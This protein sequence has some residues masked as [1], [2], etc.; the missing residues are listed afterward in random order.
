MFKLAVN[1]LFECQGGDCFEFWIA[2]MFTYIHLIVV[3]AIVYHAL[4]DGSWS[5]LLICQ[6]TNLANSLYQ[7][8]IELRPW[9]ACKRH[10]AHIV[11]R[12]HQTMCQHLQGVESRIDR[13]LCLRKPAL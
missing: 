13:D 10:D 12:H 1:S 2:Q 11:V 3:I 5:M 4:G 8:F 6:H 7:C 9:A